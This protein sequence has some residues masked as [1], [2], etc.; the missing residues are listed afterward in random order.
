MVLLGQE[1]LF[2]MLCLRSMYPGYKY[3]IIVMFP[4][5]ND[6]IVLVLI[7]LFKFNINYKRYQLIDIEK[8][9]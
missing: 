4:R 8:Q 7:W 1:L 3:L 5:V 6:R 2:M 9:R